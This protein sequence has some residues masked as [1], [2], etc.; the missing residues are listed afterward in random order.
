MTTIGLGKQA[1]AEEAHAHGLAESVQE[2]PKVALAKG[3]V[4][5]GIN[6]IENG[7][8]QPYHV[9]VVEPSDFGEA[10]RR[11]LDMVRP[12]VARVPFER[13]DVLVMQYIG[14]NISGG[15]MDPN[16]VGFF[17]AEGKGEWLPDFTRIVALDLTD[18]TQ[19]NALGLGQAD[20]VTRRLVKKID[21]HATY[22]NML[23]AAGKGTRL[24]EAAVPIT[25]ESDREAIEVAARSAVPVG[26]P[27]ICWIEH[28][29]ALGDLWISESLLSEAHQN[30]QVEVLGNSGAWPFDHGGNLSWP[31]AAGSSQPAPADQGDKS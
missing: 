23:T 26:Q 22:M 4:I 19:G 24:V 8:R 1:G 12:F 9:D 6:V 10:D 29:D 11:G 18:E 31:T 15:G 17:R 30:P 3:N 7:Y 2:V 25:L 20:F 14:K 16:V 5:L 21:Y 13:L 27:R 28:T